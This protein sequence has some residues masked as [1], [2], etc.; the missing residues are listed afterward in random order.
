MMRRLSA[1]AWIVV[2]GLIL[3]M[4]APTPRTFERARPHLLAQEQGSDP[5]AAH[6]PTLRALNALG[7]PPADRVALAQRYRDRTAALSV[8]DAPP[9][10]ELGQRRPFNIVD[11]V[12]GQTRRLQAELLAQSEHLSVWAEIDSAMS[13]TDA[14]AFAARFDAEIYDPVRDLWGSEP[15]PGLDGDPRLVALFAFDVGQ[16]IAALYSSFNSYPASINP[17]SNEADMFLFNLDALGAN[18]ANDRVLGIAAHEFQHLIRHHIDPNE[19]TWVD[20]GFATFTMMHVGQGEATRS[21]WAAWRR[22]PGTQLNAWPQRADP[23]PIYGAATSFVH[24]FYQRYGQGALRAVSQEGRDGLAGF[25]AVLRDMGEPG[26]DHFFGDWTV[27]NLTDAP[28]LPS[29]PPLTYTATLNGAQL[30]W[31]DALDQY[32]AAYFHLPDVSD[33]DAIEVALNAPERVNV[34]PLPS[35]ATPGPVWLSARADDSHLTLTRPLD[36]RATTTGMTWV[37]YRIWYDLERFWDYA[38]VSISADAGQTWELQRAFNMT[39]ENPAGRAYGPGYTGRSEG[40]IEEWLD[41]TRYDGQQILLRFEVITDDATTQAGLALAEVKLPAINY[42]S[43]FAREA[44][45]WDAEGWYL[46][47]NRLPQRAWVQIVQRTPEGD[48][49][50]R[51]RFPTTDRL[52]AQLLP[53]ASEAWVILAPHAPATMI[54]M[55][56]TLDIT[57]PGK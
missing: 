7:I 19:S 3:G 53:G 52:R 36:L 55:P 6:S 30:R 44:S 48:R 42:S 11:N 26:V 28:P 20:E 1:C 31:T 43:A 46:S 22:N 41:L 50:T 17:G 27:S 45:A 54:A 9:T 25:D 47:D 4:L 39:D 32:A 35:R 10:W 49:V 51:G 24:H 13:P 15:L 5:E 21:F 2:G 29:L 16:N 18:P 14:A 57:L 56:Y 37:S 38:Y 23:L 8:P 33:A 34:M 12:S 40:W